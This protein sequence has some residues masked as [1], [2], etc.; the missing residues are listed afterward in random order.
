MQIPNECL[1]IV[2]PGS[3]FKKYKFEYQQ[4]SLTYYYAKRAENRY[5]RSKNK[6]V[7]YGLNNKFA[8][9][10]DA[11]DGEIYGKCIIEIPPKGKVIFYYKEFKPSKERKS[12]YDLTSY[13]I[14]N[15][16][17]YFGYTLSGCDRNK[18][19]LIKLSKKSKKEEKFIQDVF[20]VGF[21]KKT[22]KLNMGIIRKNTEKTIKDLGKEF[23]KNPS[24]FLYE[25]EVQGELVRRLN[26]RFQNEIKD[27]LLMVKYEGVTTHSLKRFDIRIT[28][29]D[30]N[31]KI[32]IEVKIEKDT[33]KL[34][35]ELGKDKE[36]I[37]RAKAHGFI[38]IFSKEKYSK[39]KIDR[40]K[41]IFSGERKIKFNYFEIHNPKIFAEYQINYLKTKK[42]I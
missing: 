36:K 1:L 40:F 24:R 28:D 13:T 31:I 26:K 17:K 39:K 3:D 35:N 23:S 19:N 5:R 14:S 9:L 27:K 38:V 32:C 18:P 37:K 4:G 25:K 8:I 30:D 34:S 22:K 7:E 11:S 42:A 20:K 16:Y 2:L 33:T 10:M 21:T 29:M 12:Y 41:S 15:W 6:F